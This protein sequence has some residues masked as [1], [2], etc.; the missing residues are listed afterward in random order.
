MHIYCFIRRT[1]ECRQKRSKTDQGSSLLI[2][3]SGDII[4][5]RTKGLIFRVQFDL[6]DTGIG[7]KWRDIALC[8]RSLKHNFDGSYG[9]K[10]YTDF[11]SDMLFEALERA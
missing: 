5:P 2:R 10:V 1:S 6:G 4:Y 9:G 8:Y 3:F 7:D 11:D